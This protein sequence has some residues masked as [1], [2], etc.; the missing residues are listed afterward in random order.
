MM[1]AEALNN[2]IDNA[3]RYTPA[4]GHVTVHVIATPFTV[5][6]AVE[7]SGPGIQP[8]ERERVFDRFYRVLGTR[9]DGSGLGLAIV[10]EVAQRHQATVTILDA[11]ALGQDRP[12]SGSWIELEFK[13]DT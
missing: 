6:L 5:R 11:P 13:R 4:P 7:D 10:R 8:E 12:A 2:L 1:L 9:G 3:I